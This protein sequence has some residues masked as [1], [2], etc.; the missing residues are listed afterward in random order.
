LKVV[1]IQ[2]EPPASREELV[3]RVLLANLD[4]LYTTAH[5]IG[6]AA[7]V[8]EDAVQETARKALKAAPFL[9]DDRSVRAWLFRILINALRDHFRLR[10]L[11]ED[12]DPDAKEFEARVDLESV[13]RATVHDVRAALKMLKPASKAMVVLID[14]EGFT[15]AEAADMLAIPIGTAASRLAR[16][17]A[18]LRKLLSAYE[19][20]SSQRGGGL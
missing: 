12:L 7:D 10:R 17:R 8:A 4:A 2:L 15:L 3:Y 14:I 11:W 16:A 13:T 5:R 6:G 1:P 20:N 9:K 18:E 19:A